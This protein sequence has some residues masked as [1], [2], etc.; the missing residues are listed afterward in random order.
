MALGSLMSLSK[1]E[2][3]RG[4]LKKTKERRKTQTCKQYEL[5]IDSSHLSDASLNH[6]HRLF[7]EAK[8]LY[9]H[10]L[11]NGNLF[12]TDYRIFT[13]QIKTKRALKLEKSTASLPR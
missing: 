1:N 4:T 13:A 2:T 12:E 3:I 10:V 9:N 6:L 7:L 8:W 11:G 5:K